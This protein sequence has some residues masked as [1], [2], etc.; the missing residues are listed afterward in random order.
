VDYSGERRTLVE[1]TLKPQGS[2]TKLTVVESGFEHLPENRRLEAFRMNDGGW[3][4][5]LDNIAKYVG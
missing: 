4:E 3:A 2:G 1:F 5:Q